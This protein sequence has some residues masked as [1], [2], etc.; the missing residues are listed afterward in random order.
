MLQMI[1]DVLKEISETQSDIDVADDV[2]VSVV[3][4]EHNVIKLLKKDGSLSSKQLSV[5]ISV[6]QRQV[7][8]I[9]AK[10]KEQ[11]IIVRHG[12]SKSGY[13]EVAEKPN[14]KKR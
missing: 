11:G 13:W 3:T 5:S 8:R 9:L 7:Q 14:K 6:T 1:C 12:N 2:V 10:L 4:N